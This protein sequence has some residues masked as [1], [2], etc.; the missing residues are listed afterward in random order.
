MTTTPP[1]TV[2]RNASADYLRSRWDD[3]VA[4]ALDPVARLI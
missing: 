1:R 4:A 2:A 3:A